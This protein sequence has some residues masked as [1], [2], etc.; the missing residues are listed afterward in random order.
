MGNSLY[1]SNHQSPKVS[2][3]LHCAMFSQR[4]TSK[5]NMQI[6]KIAKKMMEKGDELL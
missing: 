2:Q 4:V 3:L 6:V 5:C 1:H